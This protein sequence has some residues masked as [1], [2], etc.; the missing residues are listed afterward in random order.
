MNATQGR[1]LAATATL[2]F[3][4]AA[5]APAAAGEP[6]TDG[7]EPA[8]PTVLVFGLGNRC[9][10]CVQLKK[11]IATVTQ[12]TGDAVRFREF[13]VNSDLEMV[14]K[15]RVLLSPTL[16]FLDAGGAEVFRYQGALDAAQ[17]LERLIALKFWGGKG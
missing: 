13:L 16:V 14:R 12:T 9:W 8:R 5:G 3:L 1:R 7:G 6:A 11:E 2:C 4:L 10:Y 15:Y 17:I